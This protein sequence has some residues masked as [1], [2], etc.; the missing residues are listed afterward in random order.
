MTSRIHDLLKDSIA[1]YYFMQANKKRSA[2]QSDR[3][4]HIVK[5]RRAGKTYAEIGKLYGISKQRA[6]K[7]F[8][9]W[10]ERC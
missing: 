8:K 1:R 5:L 2:K 3:N 9:D 4:I 10:N 7:I 6:A